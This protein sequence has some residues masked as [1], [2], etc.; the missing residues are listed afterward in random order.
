[1][2]QECGNAIYKR[3]TCPQ[4]RR[5]EPTGFLSVVSQPSKD[6]SPPGEASSDHES[7]IPR[8]AL[9]RG[10]D[11]LSPAPIVS[12]LGSSAIAPC[13]PFRR[14]IE[15]GTTQAHRRAMTALPCVRITSRVSP[16]APLPFRELSTWSPLPDS[17]LPITW[18]T[19]PGTAHHTRQPVVNFPQSVTSLHPVTGWALWVCRPG[20]RLV[21][22]AVT[23]T[24][25]LG[26]TEQ[27]DPLTGH[28]RLFAFRHRLR[29]QLPASSSEP[30]M[31]ELFTVFLFRRTPQVSLCE[32]SL[33]PEKT[34]PTPAKVV[35][36]TIPGTS[37]PGGISCKQHH[38]F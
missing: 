1:L 35:R 18:M 12:Y 38:P 23:T 34:L 26:G 4:P 30:F 6:I 37:P 24:S 17:G 28:P 36:P 21:P 8:N 11:L 32:S 2:F 15:L 25:R 9:G 31:V 22:L 14:C 13:R 33:S 5:T 20:S 19:N 16:R 3:F 29:L 10:E 27:E 7:P